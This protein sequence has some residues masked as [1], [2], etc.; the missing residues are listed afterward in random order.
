MFERLKYKLKNL[1]QK[2]Q[3][4]P[5]EVA[6]DNVSS[7]PSSVADSLHALEQR[8]MFDAAGVAT[9]SEVA[10]EVVAEE[11]AEQ[12][13]AADLTDVEA[14]AVVES[15]DKLFEALSLIDA[16]SDSNEIIFIDR[17]VDDFE[18]LLAGISSNAE[19]IFLDSNS[20]GV[21]QIADALEG[22]ENID[23]IHIIAH[24]DAGQLQLGNSVLTQ[25]SM[26]GEHTDELATIGKALGE[27]ADILI[28][29]C[30]FGQGVEGLDA[31]TT[32]S[33]LTG[34]DIAASDDLTGAAELGGD[35]DLETQVGQ[36]ETDVFADVTTLEKWANKL[37]LT[38]DNTASDTD[39]GTA[40]SPTGTGMNITNAGTPNSA[41][42]AAN[43]TFAGGDSTG[44][45]VDAGVI[46]T[47][48]RTTTLIDGN[49][50]PT[51]TFL[52]TNNTNAN[53]DDAELDTIVAGNQVDRSE[54]THNFTTDTGVNKIAIAYVF[55]TEEDP[56]VGGFGDDGFGIFFTD[57]LDGDLEPNNNAPW[58]TLV[59]ESVS[60]LYNGGA[61]P[62]VDLGTDGTGTQLDWST[63]TITAV[64][65]VTPGTDYFM[66]YELADYDNSTGTDT[67]TFLTYLGSTLSLDADLDDDSGAAGNFDY[68]TTYD[69]D[70]TGAGESI[71]DSDVT[72]TN[73]DTTDID[74]A[75]ITLTNAIA[76]DVLDASAVN[77][78]LFDVDT[79]VADE[80]TISAAS[81][82][83]PTAAE[84]ETAL[85]AITF[86]TTASSLTDRTITIVLDDT[87]TV[88]NTTTTTITINTVNVAPTD[89]ALSS[90]SVL[91]ESSI[92]TLVGALSATDTAGST[93]TYALVAGAGDTDNASFQISG[94]DLQT[95]AV[96][97]F[98][99]Q[100][101]YDIRLE[102][103]DEGGLTFIE[104]FTISATNVNEIDFAGTGATESFTEN[105]AATG[106]LFNVTDLDTIEAGDDITSVV[107]NLGN[108]VAGD[109]LQI[110]G[111]S[112]DVGTDGVI[113]P[114]SFYTYTVSGGG[115]VLTID[116]SV[117]QSAGSIE[118]LLEGIIFTGTGEDPGN[119]TRSFTIDS[120][121]DDGGLVDVTD[122]TAT[123]AITPVNDAPVLAD[124][125]DLAYIEGDGTVTLDNAITITD[126][127]DTD[128]ESAILTLGAGY[129][130]GED[131]LAFA[132]TANIAAVWNAGA[133]T[134]TLTGS[135]TLANYE[136]ALESITYSSSA[137]DN[138]TGG[139]RNLSWIV[140]DGDDNSNTGA[141]T[142]TVTPV[143]DE[144]VINDT[145]AAA[146]PENSANTTFVYDVN[147]ALTTNDTD[148][149]GDA[150]TYSITAG[151]GLGAFIINSGT[152]V[153]T[154]LD[155][156][157]LDF[158]TTPSFVLTVQ[159]SDGTLSDTADITINLNNI[160]EASPTLTSGTTATA[161]DENSGA[162]QSVYTVVATDALDIS[163]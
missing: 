103:T 113:G 159:A 64:A 100:S 33:Q 118:T 38:I 29:G 52:S 89:I 54:F 51:D 102:V 30:N 117:G 83:T 84:F 141:S 156:N 68:D 62:L 136:L 46:F 121:T 12:A 50:D 139:V 110:N 152:G 19:V 142:I 97:D 57:D 106:T 92:G 20:D 85:K 79:T 76:G 77:T 134:L 41:D 120:I 145:T 104:T 109:T 75:T 71:V 130:N 101:S 63:G 119:A 99:A 44:L 55:L 70:P 8:F 122:V 160:D 137:G 27:N 114:L 80:V 140:N 74:S 91:E 95:A 132:D 144:P 24:G 135:D 47:T 42:D 49:D 157:Q 154:V 124:I 158:E 37:A 94:G 58:T 123:V 162:G 153:I 131:V 129:I 115:T 59:G 90:T 148:V 65:T 151:N 66:K 127:D 14:P 126:V 32:L 26:Q 5:E 36:I 28:Y 4:T 18:T 111:T 81:G 143:N 10:A 40:L 86:E 116:H 72:I 7:S 31:A 69:Y 16:P 3:E 82:Q 163:A 48:G 161:I 45:G 22:R 112:V 23:A 13:F 6:D 35:W 146:L 15:A 125:G 155:T 107:I 96:L 17:S 34:A 11:Q 88:S 1:K 2:K 67:A 43:G 39:M 61:G 149:D 78:T 87:E 25:E 105:G 128:I 147:D 133:G 53:N 150:I 98:E 9:G 21:Q 60:S 73:Y 108:T 93:F 56:T 138:P